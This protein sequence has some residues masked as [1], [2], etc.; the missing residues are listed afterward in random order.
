MPQFNPTDNSL[1]NLG[2]PTGL[3]EHFPADPSAD[4]LAC[5]LSTLVEKIMPVVLP[6]GQIDISKIWGNKETPA[7]IKTLKTLV[8][9]ILPVER[10]IYINYGRVFIRYYESGDIFTDWNKGVEELFLGFKHAVIISLGAERVLDIKFNKDPSIQF[11]LKLN[12]GSMLFIKPLL[13]HD[14][15][16]RIPKMKGISQPMFCLTLCAEHS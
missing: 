10:G 14:W 9:A 13:V 16:V 12:S 8:K 3:L 6:Q 4:S 2:I 11:S 1:P 5:M 15:N 7:L